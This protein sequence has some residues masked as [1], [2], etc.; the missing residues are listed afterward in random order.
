MMIDSEFA[1]PRVRDA[2]LCALD[3]TARRAEVIQRASSLTTCR[4]PLPGTTCAQ[5][6][7]PIG[8]SYGEAARKILSERAAA[9]NNA[10]Y[11]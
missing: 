6:N 11:P 3:D 1:P 2:F 4:N 5:L 10:I 9:A 8:S 7:L